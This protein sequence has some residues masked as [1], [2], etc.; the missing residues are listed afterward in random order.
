MEMKIDRVGGLHFE[1]WSVEGTE[2]LLGSGNYKIKR[3]LKWR[4]VD[5][6]RVIDGNRTKAY[7]GSSKDQRDSTY[8]SYYFG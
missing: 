8:L 3:K 5:H 6:L 1:V 7:F 4:R 2:L